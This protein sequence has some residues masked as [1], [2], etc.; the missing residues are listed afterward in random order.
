MLSGKVKWLKM[1]EKNWGEVWKFCGWEVGR[2]GWVFLRGSIASVAI[3]WT[4][5]D[6]GAGV[7]AFVKECH[8]C[9]NLKLKVSTF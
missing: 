1:E 2:L 4:H 6:K 3:R 8:D 5:E 9:G 7:A